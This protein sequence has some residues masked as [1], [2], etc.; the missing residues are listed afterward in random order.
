MW[1]VV[2]I[3]YW[4]LFAGIAHWGAW[5]YFR[6]AFHIDPRHQWLT[7]R[8]QPR[9]E[10]VSRIE[11]LKIKPVVVVE[12][13]Q[14]QTTLY[15]KLFQPSA[16]LM[17]WVY[18]NESIAQQT[19]SN[20]I[21]E[22]E[23]KHKN[24]VRQRRAVCFDVLVLFCKLTKSA[25]SL[26]CA[27]VL[28]VELQDSFF[29]PSVLIGMAMEDGKGVP[30]PPPFNH[31]CSLTEAECECCKKTC[32]RQPHKWQPECFLIAMITKMIFEEVCKM[33]CNELNSLLSLYFV[34]P[35][36]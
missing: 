7:I 24:L 11:Q 35:P 9:T 28:L 23:S 25:A 17:E 10:F 13:T 21:S 18:W 15:R 1:S 4:C 8:V 6:D 12:T 27:F 2:Y 16:R 29:C 32:T 36:A 3:I 31:I 33:Q 30:P 34:L 26:C 14:T 22:R 5:R 20:W 19:V